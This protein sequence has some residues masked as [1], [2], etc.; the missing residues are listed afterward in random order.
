MKRFFTAALAAL[1]YSCAAAPVPADTHNPS[2][3]WDQGNLKRND[4][5]CPTAVFVAPRGELVQCQWVSV[6][7][8]AHA[9]VP[10]VP[11]IEEAALD[12]LKTIM[13]KPSANFY[14]WGGAIVKTTSGYVALPAHSDYAAQHVHIEEEAGDIVG[15]Y[16]THVCHSSFAHEFFS[17]ADMSD[18]IFFHRVAFMGDICTGLAHMFKPGDKPDVNQVGGVGS[19][20]LSQ[21]RVIGKFTTPHSAQ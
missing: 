7:E 2:Q 1:L 13:L 18:P 9:V 15:S 11:T 5:G 12:G 6:G 20:W 4:D 17:P 3:S 8:A 21:G 19:P 10:G 16:H 14:E